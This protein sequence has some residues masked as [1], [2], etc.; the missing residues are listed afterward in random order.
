M[1]QQANDSL[2]LGE[3]L[4]EIDLVVIPPVFMLLM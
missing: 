2:A 3:C 4:G 1:K